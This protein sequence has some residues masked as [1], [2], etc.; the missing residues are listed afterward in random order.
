MRLLLPKRAHYFRGLRHDQQSGPDVSVACHE[1]AEHQWHFF[2]FFS[3]LV[4]TY[5]CV[6]CLIS[7]SEPVS[8]SVNLCFFL[9]VCVS[10]CVCVCVSLSLSLSLSFA[11]FVIRDRFEKKPT[12]A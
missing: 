4:H 1:P 11:V 6:L 7:N 10:V 9:C 3:F 8:L 5:G 2:L 12:R